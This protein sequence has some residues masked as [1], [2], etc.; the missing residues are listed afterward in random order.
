MAKEKGEG[1][2]FRLKWE[3]REKEDNYIEETRIANADKDAPHLLM[4]HGYGSSGVLFY[5]MVADLKA[6]FNITLIDF[7]GMGCSGRPAFNT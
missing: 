2:P 1:F 3:C 6:H 5:R 7:L 4:F